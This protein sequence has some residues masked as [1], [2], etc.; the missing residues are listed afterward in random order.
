M[1][2]TFLNFSVAVRR[3]SR[4]MYTMYM[5]RV[6]GISTYPLYRVMIYNI[7]TTALR[8]STNIQCT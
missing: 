5:H 2:E 1:S 4:Y 8:R 3:N 6:H 7:H